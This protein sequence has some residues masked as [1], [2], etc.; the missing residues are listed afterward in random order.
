VDKKRD[1]SRNRVFHRGN[2]LE[3]PPEKSEEMH[4]LTGSIPAHVFN[5]E[6]IA[7]SAN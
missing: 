2:I 6:S 7:S 4:A 5:L 3:L 1:F